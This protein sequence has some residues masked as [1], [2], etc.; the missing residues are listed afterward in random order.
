MTP[1]RSSIILL[2]RIVLLLIVAGGVA[3]KVIGKTSE[4]KSYEVDETIVTLRELLYADASLDQ[5]L[6]MFQPDET[7]FAPEVMAALQANDPVAAETALAK[8]NNFD[9]FSRTLF[10]WLAMAKT[11]QMQ[12]NLSAAQ[13]AA[14]QIL[15]MPELE[16]RIQ[17]QTWSILRELGYSPN[18]NEAEKVLGVV[19]E[20]G[21]DEGAAII[22]GFADGEARMFLTSGGGIIGEMRDEG[23][24]TAAKA[25]VERAENLTP[26]LPLETERPL[27]APDRIRLVLL[28][29]AGMRAVDEAVQDIENP[30][31]ELHSVYIAMHELLSNLIRLYESGEG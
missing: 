21:F 29:P 15:K 25:L 18:E 22:A 16:A 6:T 26:L 5:T 7:E 8:F 27:P 13:T 19:A 2:V 3:A 10:Y 12:G 23:V 4:P 17:I 24:I 31:H 1:K 9:D 30:G 28:T 14:L 20:M 11:R